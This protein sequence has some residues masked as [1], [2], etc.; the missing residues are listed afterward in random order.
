MPTNIEKHIMTH[1]SVE[2]AG[3]I[4]LPHD[5]DGELPL[6]FVVLRE[7]KSVTPEEI[8]NYTN[9]AILLN[10]SASLRVE[11]INY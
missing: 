7:G 10:L 5:V 9:G 1:P 6:A 4:G 11:L 8:I 3:V 2:D